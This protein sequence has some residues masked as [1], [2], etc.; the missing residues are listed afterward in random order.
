MKAKSE[1]DK[2]LKKF[3]QDVG[4]PRKLIF[5]GAMEQVG[6]DTEFQKLLG[7]YYILDH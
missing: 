3:I 7:T 2:T 4:V 6:P 5:D 1:T